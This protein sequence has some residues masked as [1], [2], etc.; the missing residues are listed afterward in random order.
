MAAPPPARLRTPRRWRPHAP[1]A[2]GCR[3]PAA[4]A[5]CARAPTPPRRRRD[6]LVVPAMDDA[7]RHRRGVE[8]MRRRP[9]RIGGAIRNRPATGTC[10]DTRPEIQA[11]RLEPASTSGPRAAAACASAQ[12]ALHAR[13]DVAEFADL[14]LRV[15]VG[16]IRTFAAPAQAL[17]DFGQRGD[18]GGVG[19]A[20]ETV[21]ED[22]MAAESMPVVHSS[23][24]TMASPSGSCRRR[25]CVRT[26]RH[27]RALR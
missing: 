24:A 3:R 23:I 22:A 26:G 16:E 6:Q 19:A 14:A 2:D 15:Q 7:G 27:G 17:G 18:L 5:R 1:T 4:A 12:Q 13:G 11:P 10:S 20:L 21:G 25:G 9:S 8:R